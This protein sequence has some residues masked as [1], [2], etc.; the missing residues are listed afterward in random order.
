MCGCPFLGSPRSSRNP[1]YAS[2]GLYLK[3]SRNFSTL[4]G[5][6]GNAAILS[7]SFPVKIPR[8]TQCSKKGSI[9]NSSSSQA[10]FRSRMLRYR[11]LILDF[12]SWCRPCRCSFEFL[13]AAQSPFST[14]CRYSVCHIHAPS[15]ECIVWHK[16]GGIISDRDTVCCTTVNPANRLLT[17]FICLRKQSS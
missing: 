5:R 12:H 16:S 2:S 7:L 17:L 10:R 6:A 1:S 14:R 8:S 15:L 4:S 9:N 3:I 11:S 13:F